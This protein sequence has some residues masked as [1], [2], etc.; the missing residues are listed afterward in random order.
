MLELHGWAECEQNSYYK[1]IQE[2][3]RL[4][5]EGRAAT[6][7][8]S[9]RLMEWLRQTSGKTHTILAQAH[10]RKDADSLVQEWRCVISQHFGNRYSVSLTHSELPEDQQVRC[11][12]LLC[13]QT[14]SGHGICN[15]LPV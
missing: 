5:L 6:M 2:A 3:A 11:P 12:L 15:Q 7:R 13:K 1:D 8:H 4:S 14:G 10:D 9:L